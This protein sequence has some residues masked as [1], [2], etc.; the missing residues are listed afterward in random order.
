M[1]DTATGFSYIY[2]Q[3]SQKYSEVGVTFPHYYS[4][5]NLNLPQ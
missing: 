3:V 5:Q 1:A 2:P 4:R